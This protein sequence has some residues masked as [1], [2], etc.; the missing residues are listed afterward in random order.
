MRVQVTM[1]VPGLP[2]PGYTFP[3][4]PKQPWNPKTTALPDFCLFPSQF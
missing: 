1:L 4:I 2:S 3:E